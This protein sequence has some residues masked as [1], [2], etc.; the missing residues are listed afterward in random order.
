MVAT[1]CFPRQSIAAF[2][3]M[4]LIGT[5]LSA[6]TSDVEQPTTLEPPP[7][8]VS[9]PAV[10]TPPSGEPEP[11]PSAAP[12]LPA[13]GR[14]QTA[15]GAIAFVRHYFAVVDYAYATGDT[16]PL[17]VAS[18]P[19]CLACTKVKDTVDST[20]ISGGSYVTDATQITDLRVS[21]AELMDAEEVLAHYSTPAA[22]AIDS[23]G[24]TVRRFVPR[25]DMKASL[26]VLWQRSGWLVE[27]FADVA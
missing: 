6:C 15:A 2:A 22:A 20:I 25:S 14:E 13:E 5:L 1:M 4:T 26:I 18:D 19:A 11:S 27:D 21:D 16:A 17:A 7:A 12:I 3:A 8:A 10:A 24:N 9:T 23:N